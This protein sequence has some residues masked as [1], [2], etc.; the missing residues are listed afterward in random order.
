[1]KKIGINGFGRIGRNVFKVI[2]EKYSNELEVV[3]VNDLTDAKT[4]AHLLM[5]DSIYGKFS[6]SIRTTEN[7]L[8]VN[9]K[10]I[11]ILAERDPANINW[12]EFGIDLVLESTGLFTKREKAEIHITKGGAR[13]VIISAPAVGDDIT[14][15]YGVNEDKYDPERHHVIS[16]ASCTTNCLAPV[17]KV[18][19]DHLKIIKGFMTTVHAYTN[20]QRILD[21]PHSDLRRARAAAMSIIPTKTGAAKAIGLVVPELSG[22]LNGFS[23]RVPVPTVS[24]VDLVAEI[25]K[26]VTKEE[27]NAILRA[28]ADGKMK[29]I[30]SYSEEPL[31]S[32][33]YIGDPASSIIDALSTMVIDSNL[34]KVVSWYDNEWGYS[35]RC[36]DLVHY[37][38]CV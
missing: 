38:A 5:H 30:M 16:S 4:L 27:V 22:K 8:I 35:N 28:A 18:L 26:T 12:K 9:E 11:R 29:G 31:V 14:I 13:K 32:S 10:E 6:G 36:A 33:D 15:V 2:Q 25:D 17:A 20:D 34:I 23:L 1:M 3:A 21:L 19:N 7:S 37:I 24:V